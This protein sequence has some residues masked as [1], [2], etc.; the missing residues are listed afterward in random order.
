M[1]LNKEKVLK[2]LG[3]ARRAGKVA[4]G[5]DNVLKLLRENKLKFVFIASDA[6]KKQIDKFTKKC[7]YYNVDVNNDF[8]CEELSNAIG[9]PMCKYLG[10]TDQG[11]LD[12]LKK[13]LMEVL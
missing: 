3:L 7:F 12:A 1:L 8:T 6:S 9:K 4:S 5:E 10:I 13:S 11:F 2:T